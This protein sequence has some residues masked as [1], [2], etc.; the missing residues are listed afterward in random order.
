VLAGGPDAGRL[1]SSLAPWVKQVHGP[2]TPVPGSHVDWVFLSDMHDEDDPLPRAVQRCF[3]LLRPGGHLAVTVENR[4]GLHWIADWRPASERGASTH[5]TTVR[6][7]LSRHI[8]LLRRA[9][10]DRLCA[11]AL[12]PSRDAPRAIVPVFPP[13]PPAA[14][15]MALDQVWQRA[16][17]AAA[18]L[19]LGLGVL[20]SAGLMRY[21]Y[22]HYL[23][24]GRK[25]C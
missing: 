6:H 25:P 23:V 8:A 10:A 4:W 18:L 16:T 5:A 9:G 17:P 3:A 14:Q 11:Y 22:P 2:G 15:K 12:L 21:L 19:R 24:V 7:G 13:C 20:V 1:A